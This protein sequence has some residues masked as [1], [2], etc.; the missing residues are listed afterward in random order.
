MQSMFDMGC[1]PTVT[2]P[3]RPRQI[4]LWIQ[5]NEGEASWSPDGN[6][7]AFADLPW[8]E[9]STAIHFLDLRTGQVTTLPRP[10]GTAARRFG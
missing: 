9:G 7:L 3:T 8:L 4:S 10:A 6:S 5:R 1:S 2:D